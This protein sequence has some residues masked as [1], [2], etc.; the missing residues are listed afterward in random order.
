MYG[1]L[2]ISGAGARL[3]IEH[4]VDVCSHRLFLA[5]GRLECPIEDSELA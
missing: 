2:V 5:A 3:R 4:C 1:D